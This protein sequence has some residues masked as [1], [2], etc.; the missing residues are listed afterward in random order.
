MTKMQKSSFIYE[1]NQ[2]AIFL[3]KNRQVGVHTNHIDIHHHFMRYMAEDKDIYIQY[4]QSED[5]PEEIMTNN[6]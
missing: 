2:C 4:I 3:S 5:N 6:T 1:Y